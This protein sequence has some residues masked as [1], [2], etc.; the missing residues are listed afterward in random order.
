[1][2]QF[3]HGC[4]L[5]LLDASACSSVEIGCRTNV[6]TPESDAILDK[7]EG[8]H[9]PLA[10]LCTR[11][12]VEE[13]EGRRRRREDDKHPRGEHELVSLEESTGLIGGAE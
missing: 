2:R 6:Q 1:M 13:V 7:L 10:V 8:I 3:F 9:D 12:I 11:E 4:V 5:I